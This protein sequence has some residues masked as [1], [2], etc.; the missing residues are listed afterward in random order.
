MIVSTLLT[1]YLAIGFLIWMLAALSYWQLYKSSALFALFHTA[2]AL[3]IWPVSLI[4]HSCPALRSRL[5][6]WERRKGKP[7]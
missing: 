4:F 3:A 1:Y 2:D 5:I 7:R 6:A